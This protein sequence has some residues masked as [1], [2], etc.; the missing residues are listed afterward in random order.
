MVDSSNT[1]S[2]MVSPEVS[3]IH[4]VS[5]YGESANVPDSEPSLA[6]YELLETFSVGRV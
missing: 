1:T 3:R 5:A 2:P 4:I 6:T